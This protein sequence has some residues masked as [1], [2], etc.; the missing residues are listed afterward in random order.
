MKETRIGVPAVAQW[1]KK[2]TVSLRLQ[3]QSL[4]LLSELQIWCCHKLWHKLQ[5]WL[6]SS[7]AVAV[8]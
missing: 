8:V 4:A 7:I 5:I 2:L 3:V 6:G 1:V